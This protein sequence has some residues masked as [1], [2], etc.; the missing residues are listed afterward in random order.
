M[1][2]FASSLVVGPTCRPTSSPTRQRRSCPKH[3]SLTSATSQAYSSGIRFFSSSLQASSLVI[4]GCPFKLV[5]PFKEATEGLRGKPASLLTLSAF[6]PHLLAGS[7]TR[8]LGSLSFCPPGRGK[9]L[10]AHEPKCHP[11]GFSKCN[12]PRPGST[13][14]LCDCKLQQRCSGRKP[15]QCAPML[16]MK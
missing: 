5:F 8:R 13:R 12:R 6:A 11:R 9:C 15:V 7:F 2:C 1:A 4:W 14:H 10:L 16:T 3:K